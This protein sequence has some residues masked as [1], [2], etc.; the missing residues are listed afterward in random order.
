MELVAE[1]VRGGVAANAP[2]WFLMGAIRSALAVT[3]AN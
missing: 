3:G 2:Q 1:D